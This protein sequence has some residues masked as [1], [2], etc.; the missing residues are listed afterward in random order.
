[1]QRV[2]RF[3]RELHGGE[4]GPDIEAVNR[5]LA[6][7]GFLDGL[8]KLMSKPRRFRRVYNAS[9]QRG[10]NK[11]RAKTNRPQNGVYDRQLHDYLVRLDAFDAYAVKLLGQYRPAADGDDS[12]LKPA[13]DKT[14]DRVVARG[15]RYYHFRDR[16]A[17]SQARPTQLRLPRETT[18]LDC[19]GL[20]AA[21]MDFAGVLM[22][23][24]WR[25]TNTW[26]QIH[27][28]REVPL[29]HARPGDIVFYGTAPNN[30]THEALYLG[31]GRVLS[32]GHHPMGI[33]PVDYR[34]DRVGIRDMIGD[35]A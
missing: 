27:L 32:N 1:M 22:S 5:A 17:Y 10:V 18:R 2:V 26:T 14:R 15:M 21:C 34:G 6:R 35:P 13:R 8:S 30:P 16:I 25:W 20:V 3:T 23:V 19:S 9:K 28:G 24:D 33:Y 29:E 31:D 11:A 12:V 7:A 4:T